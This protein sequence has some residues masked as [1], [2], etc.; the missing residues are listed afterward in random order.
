MTPN[1]SMPSGRRKGAG[2]L[3]ASVGGSAR[4][5]LFVVIV[6]AL[7]LLLAYAGVGAGARSNLAPAPQPP[8]RLSGHVAGLYPG[9]AK[10]FRVRVANRSR[11]RWVLRLVKAV[12]A[13]PHH[14]CPAENLKL[15]PYR[16]IL[17]LPPRARRSVSLRAAMRPD[18]PDACQGK[19]FPLTFR[20]RVSR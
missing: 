11:R 14:R 1:A 2:R 20:A 13:A 3:L 15:T 4:A 6:V 8:I 7:P 16:G 18:V 5:P 17:E 10:S 12:P 19:L 9:A